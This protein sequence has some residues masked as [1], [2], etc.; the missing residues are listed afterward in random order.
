M[1]KLLDPKTI[2]KLNAALDLAL[3][4]ED[5]KTFDLI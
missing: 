5:F 3:K 1:N 4:K 2:V